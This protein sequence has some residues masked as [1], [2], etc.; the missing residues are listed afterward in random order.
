MN[1]GRQILAIVGL[2]MAVLFA[3]GKFASGQSFS[4]YSAS[5]AIPINPLEANAEVVRPSIEMKNVPLSAGITQLAKQAGVNLAI[6]EQVSNWWAEK[7]IHGRIL[8]Q[9]LLNFSWTNLTA[10]DAL[11]RLLQEYH[12]N[13]EVKPGAQIAQVTF[14]KD[15]FNGFAES[16][17]FGGTNLIPLFDFQDVPITVVLENLAMSARIN[18]IIDPYLGYDDY[19]TEPAVSVRRKN[20][21]AE[22]MFLDV[23]SKYHLSVITDTNT[24]VV[25]I[26][27]QEHDVNFVEADV[28]KKDTNLIPMIEFK[29]TLLSEA[30]E[31]LAK[32]AS[33][34][35]L[36]GARVDIDSGGHEL[37]I[38]VNWEDLT[39]AQAFA[40]ICE[41]YDL[42]ITKYPV[43]G[44]IEVKPAD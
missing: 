44:M 13:L 39:A 33:M 10:K 9:S 5:N 1:S 20:I 24:G 15:E 3:A 18:Y 27:K 8:H 34:K 17:S 42:E 22:N 36:L 2:G 12:L 19:G 21:T 7:D 4:L 11:F 29:S 38:N 35:C 31:A 40:A 37:R 16:E 25:F 28:Y 41:N 32:Q 6:D 30:L 14:M 23:C 43:S 26:R